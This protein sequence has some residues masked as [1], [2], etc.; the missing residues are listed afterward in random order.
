MLGTEKIVVNKMMVSGTDKRVYGVSKQVGTVVNGII[1][2]G[3]SMVFRARDE[4][5]QYEKTFGVKIPGA[6]LAER[7]ALQ[8]HQR[9]MYA[10]Q[11]PLGSS[12]I[13]ATHD[14]MKGHALWMIE[15]SGQLY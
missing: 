3:R 2:D 11:R 1:P 4:C 14:N 7:M 12:M 5:E 13:L 6:V 10:G 9:T 15:P 8:F